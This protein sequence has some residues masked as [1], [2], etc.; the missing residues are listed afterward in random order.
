M[1]E[2]TTLSTIIKNVKNEGYYTCKCSDVLVGEFNEYA[3]KHNLPWACKAIRNGFAFASS[4]YEL[5]N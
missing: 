5:F 4:L 3:E 2:I 1:K